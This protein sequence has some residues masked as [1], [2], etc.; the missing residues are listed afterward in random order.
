[1]RPN[2]RSIISEV[3][4]AAVVADLDSRKYPISPYDLC[5]ALALVLQAIVVAIL[6]ASRFS[7]YF[8]DGY[9]SPN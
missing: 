2:K 3:S 1:M 9:L 6:G 4:S 8:S 5:V 7:S